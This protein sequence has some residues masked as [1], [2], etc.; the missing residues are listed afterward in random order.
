MKYNA[1]KTEEKYH[2]NTLGVGQKRGME[3][4]GLEAKTKGSHSVTSTKAQAGRQKDL[5]IL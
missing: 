3:A 1:G 2:Q 5:D 4:L